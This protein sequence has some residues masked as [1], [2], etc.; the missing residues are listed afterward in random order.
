M[1]AS[2]ENVRLQLAELRGAGDD[3][4]AG[5]RRQLEEANAF[6]DASKGESDALRAQLGERDAV[7]AGLV[8]DAE[9]ALREG[10]ALRQE[11]AQ[12][13]G[14]LDKVGGADVPCRGSAVRGVAALWLAFGLGGE[15]WRNRASVGQADAAV[16]PPPSQALAARRDAE[17]RLK[18]A[19]ASLKASAAG[20]AG[21]R[22]KLEA[23]EASLRAAVGNEAG[24][25]ARA[26]VAEAGLRRSEAALEVTVTPV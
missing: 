9:K 19:E 8:G 12:S 1:L 2:E 17:T 6:S 20:L 26:E 18:E 10:D 11:L 22:A 23:S 5:L 14:E 15:A 3:G 13:R 24:L 25:R 7:V 21:L 16:R 4:E